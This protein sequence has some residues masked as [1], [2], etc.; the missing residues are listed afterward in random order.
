[1]RI[2]DWSSDVCSSDLQVLR[3]RTRQ[4]QLRTA[5]LR[6]DFIQITAN[7]IARTDRLARN[8]VIAQD[9]GLGVAAEIDDHAAAFQ[10]LDLTGDQLA[11][12]ILIGLDDLRTLS[13]A[14]F[15]HDDLLGLLRTN[16]TEEI[17]RAHV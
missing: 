1:M 9:D 3:R 4:E 11:D 6:T 17:G 5:D 7:A 12:A 13:L 14:H 16:A 15:L 10:S 2:S 8:Q